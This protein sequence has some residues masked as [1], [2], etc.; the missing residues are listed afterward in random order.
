M[1]DKV[2]VFLIPIQFNLIHLNFFVCLIDLM[3]VL[4]LLFSI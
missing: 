2:D 1:L 4:D 3:L